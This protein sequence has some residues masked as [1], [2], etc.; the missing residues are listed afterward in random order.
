MSCRRGMPLK[1]TATEIFV[2]ISMALVLPPTAGF[3]R[4]SPG[5]EQSK[6]DRINCDIAANG[7]SWTAGRTSVSGLTEEEF[8]RLLGLR[9]P[10][11]L[12]LARERALT[13]GRL[14]TAPPGMAFPSSFDW[15]AEGG[16]TPVKSQGNCGSCWAFAATAALESQ[17]LIYSGLEEDL[18]EQAVISCNTEGDDCSGGWM[19]TAY[20]LFIADGAV[21][22]ACMPYHEVDTDPCIQPSCEIA[23]SLDSYY[24]VYES[25]DAIKTAILNGPVACAVAVC[26][27]FSA[28]T[29]GCYEEDCTEINHGVL[30]VGWDDNMCSGEGA[31]IMKNSWGPDWGEAG[32]M[33]IKYGANYIGYATDGLNYVPGQTVHFFHESHLVDDS[34]GDGDG[35]IETGET[36]IL[37]VTVRNIGAETA[38]NVFGTLRCLTPGV[39]VTDSMAAFPDIPKGEARQSD[40]PHFSFIVTP[41][42]P[43]CGPLRFQIGVSSDQGNSV[44]SI[45]IQAGV[46]VTVFED[47]FE[48]DLGWTPGV[49]GDDAITGMWERADPNATYWGAEEVQPEN[50]HTP[51]SGAQCYITQQ[52]N[53]GDSQ[54]AYDVDGGVTTLVS[55]A[56]D[57]SDLQS[58]LLEYHRWYASNTGSAPNDDDFIV[59]VS[60]DGG[61]TWQNLETLSY[62]ERSWTGIRLFIEDY[63]QLTSDMR[64]RFVAADSS[65]GSIVEA[66]VDDF[67][68]LGCAGVAIDAE[69]PVVMVGNPDGGETLYYGSIHDIEWTANDN[70]GV[71]E[72]SILLSTDG[73]VT[74]PDTVSAGEANDGTYAWAVP[75]IDSKQARIKII[76]TD[77]AENVGED[78]SSGDFT[79]WGSQ[80][81]VEPGDGKRAV[82]QVSI[83]V[84]GGIVAGNRAV[85][86][87]GLPAAAYVRLSCYDPAG[88]RIALI[89]SG[90]REE[91]RHNIEWDLGTETG[92]RLG[93][94]VYFLRLDTEGDVATAKLVVAK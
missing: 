71:V 26:G 43:S 88:R 69:A 72:V 38:T 28:Y 94:G 8:Q 78:Q 37:P 81:A 25:V 51:G 70:I 41:A 42:G 85:V 61:V 47:G 74:Y 46:I 12:E 1:V 79:L 17:I 87:F 24:Y 19:E 50:D 34:A 36:I 16:V 90:R 21:R 57:L 11:G 92:S 27:G 2:L 56:I 66:A 45:V 4:L 93:P 65:P 67:L 13:E 91:G 52:S 73:G 80:S 20:D 18:S 54:G 33:Y 83:S 44:R 10:P 29:G 40:S 89:A 14:I 84:P 5:E 62:T 23:S 53:P 22:E 68:I 86:E 58:A 7:Y 9:V 48:T 55:P 3:A 6:I 60:N 32:F 30:L 77:A 31:W 64:F 63:V 35:Y 82:E 39:V 15:R 76:A 49:P 75:D 59:D